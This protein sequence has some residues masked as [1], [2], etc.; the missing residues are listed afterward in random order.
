MFTFPFA[1][2]CTTNTSSNVELTLPLPLFKETQRLF[3]AF[4]P[5]QPRMEGILIQL[6]KC[7]HLTE[8]VFTTSQESRYRE[9]NN[10]SRMTL[11][12]CLGVPPSDDRAIVS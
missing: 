9:G 2:F 5:P 8:R 7:L 12:V 3:V 10:Q 11:L 6:S 1:R 4:L